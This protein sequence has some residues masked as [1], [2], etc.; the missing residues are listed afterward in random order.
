MTGGTGGMTW[1]APTDRA[2]HRSHAVERGDIGAQTRRFCESLTSKDSSSC[3]MRRLQF[4][5]NGGVSGIR[6][7]VVAKSLATG[8]NGALRLSPVPNQGVTHEA[9]GDSQLIR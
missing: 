9:V 8:G 1:T 4:Q 6:S 7:Q 2:V 5:G 3:Q